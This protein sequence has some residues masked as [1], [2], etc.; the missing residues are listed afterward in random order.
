MIDEQKDKYIDF[1]I[2]VKVNDVSD[3]HTKEL[4]KRL[5]EFENNELGSTSWEH[6]SFHTIHYPTEF[7]NI[8]CDT[9][10]GMTSHVS[11]NGDDF[12]CLVCKSKEG[13]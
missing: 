1:V 11:I 13:T 3:F 6:I 8:F 10:E 2:R 5:H 9:C 4:M 12:V 7:K